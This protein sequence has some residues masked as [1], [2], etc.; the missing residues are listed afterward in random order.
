MR[1]IPANIVSG[2]LG[3]GKTS[4]IIQL[5]GQKTDANSISPTLGGTNRRK[6]HHHQ[7]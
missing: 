3:A 2:F 4:A 7:K 1:K 5:L 6:P